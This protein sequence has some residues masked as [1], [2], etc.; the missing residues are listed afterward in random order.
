MVNGERTVEVITTFQPP[1]HVLVGSTTPVLV[2]KMYFCDTPHRHPSSVIVGIATLEGCRIPFLAGRSSR[3]V[4]SAGSAKTPRL[5]V[6][7]KLKC[8][9]RPSP[10]ASQV[11][12]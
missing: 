9:D 4:V 5:P 12:S 7:I 10:S 1:S 2:L 3:L 8:I 6:V 11:L